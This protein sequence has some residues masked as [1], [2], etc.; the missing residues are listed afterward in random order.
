VLEERR[1]GTSSNTLFIAVAVVLLLYFPAV[2]LGLLHG[3]RQLN[4]AF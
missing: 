1:D 4:H 2:C 3:W